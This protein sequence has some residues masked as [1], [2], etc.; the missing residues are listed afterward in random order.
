MD[1]IQT[2]GVKDG[3]SSSLVGARIK[4]VVLGI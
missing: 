2:K 1:S 3:T 4:K